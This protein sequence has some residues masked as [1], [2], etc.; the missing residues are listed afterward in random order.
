[1]AQNRY[2]PL[3]KL[4]QTDRFLPQTI[5]GSQVLLRTALPRVFYI[6]SIRH[7]LIL[8]PD[9]LCRSTGSLVFDVVALVKRPDDGS[10]VS[11]ISP[12]CPV[13]SSTMSDNDSLSLSE[14]M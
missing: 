11:G 12:T 13:R 2:M 1:M 5:A 14:L 6:F 4:I 10:R 7:V 9:Y 8:E 3:T